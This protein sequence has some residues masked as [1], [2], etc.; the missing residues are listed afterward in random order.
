MAFLQWLSN[1]SVDFA[2]LQ[3]TH[4]LSD[5]E[6]SSWFSSCGFQAVCSS[7]SIH[8]CGSVIIFR[9]IY[10]LVN[11]WKDDAGRFLMIE[12]SFH[13]ISFRIICLY[14]PN[15]NP[16][17]DEFFAACG[18]KIDPSIPIVVGGDF[19]ALFNRLLDR[20][21]SNIFNVSR[22][23]C[24]A[25]SSLFNDCAMVDIWRYLHPQ[26]VAFTWMRPDGS[27]SSRID[28]FGCP[29]V[30]LHAVQSCDLLACPYSDHCAVSLM[31]PIPEPIPRGPGSWKLNVTILADDSFKV[32]VAS[33][34]LSWRARKP[35]FV[36]I[37]EW[38]DVG[39]SKLKSIAISFCASKSKACSLERS[40]L[41]NLSNHLKGQID[42][43]RVSLLDIYE[44]VLS[45]LAAL[46][47]SAAEGARIRSR[48]RWAEEGEASTKYFFQV[49]K[50]NGSEE[51]ISAMKRADC[52]LA[53]TIPAICDS[54]VSFYDSL[55]RA[56]PV[57]LSLQSDLLD[58][59][60]PFI[61]SGEQDTCEG[62]FTS[63]E[64]YTTLKGMAMGKAPG[65]DGFPAEFYCLFGMCLEVILWMSLT[66]PLI[67]EFCPCL[68]GRL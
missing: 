8:S 48:T 16:E 17:R 49:A 39:K 19:N 46:D 66:L 56:C 26:T 53:T 36:S 50:K 29:Y 63:D 43:G 64:V 61:P 33:F 35:S 60:V 15:R 9:P 37:Q 42:L 24:A 13:N 12:L 31:C 2:C 11:S 51:W 14:A 4:V 62:Y 52:S 58:K 23:S 21:G 18:L 22:E 57:D 40:L 59:L 10:S 20:R 6:C 1:L 34:W 27:L 38:W 45:R 30:W 47:S 32:S 67:R 5:D 54:W 3:E 7:G 41:T 65:T 68:S 44:S 25:L 55:F 28:F